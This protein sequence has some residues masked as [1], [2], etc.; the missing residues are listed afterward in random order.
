MLVSSPSLVLIYQRLFT[1]PIIKHFRTFYKMLEGGIQKSCNTKLHNFR[2]SPWI[3][4]SAPCW[5]NLSSCFW[6]YYEF[7][8]HLDISKTN[9][10]ILV[11]LGHFGTWLPVTL[12]TC[13]WESIVAMPSSKAHFCDLPQPFQ[14]LN[15]LNWWEMQSYHTM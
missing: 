13:H 12:A 1:L 9:W 2:P 15:L 7:S 4:P 8:K 6:N 14:N 11:N 3:A 10:N 5:N